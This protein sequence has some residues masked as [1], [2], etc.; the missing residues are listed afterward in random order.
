MNHHILQSYSITCYFILLLVYIK[1][2]FTWIVIHFK[3]IF[4]LGGAHAGY[5]MMQRNHY[6][7]PHLHLEYM[8][9]SSGLLTYHEIGHNLQESWGSAGRWNPAKTVEVTNLIFGFMVT[10]KVCNLL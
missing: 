7:I 10:S 1:I 4:I 2:V 8:G 3:N 9:S 5:P 6:S